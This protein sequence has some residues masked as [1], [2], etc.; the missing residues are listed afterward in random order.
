[1]RATLIHKKE[2]YDATVES[3]GKRDQNRWYQAHTTTEGWKIALS[4]D[5]PKAFN[6]GDLAEIVLSTDAGETNLDAHPPRYERTETLAVV[7][8]CTYWDTEGTTRWQFDH[9]DVEGDLEAL[10]EE[11]DPSLLEDGDGDD[12]DPVVYS[13]K[14]SRV[15]TGSS[16]SSGSGSSSN[17]LPDWVSDDDVSLHIDG[18]EIPIKN[19]STVR[20]PSDAIV[21]YLKRVHKSESDD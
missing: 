4:H 11:Y 16:N 3:I 5:N 7:A 1:M 13:N 10:L 20:E 21:D 19:F 14:S 2:R 6:I 17:G 8:D 9:R 15:N 18:E 12:N